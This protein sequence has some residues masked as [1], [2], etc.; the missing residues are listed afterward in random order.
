MEHSS[1]ADSLLSP[2]QQF[3]V[4]Y[5][6]EHAITMKVLRAYPPGKADLRPHPKCRTAKELA[7]VFVLE[8][9]LGTMVM[10]DY[11][12]SNPPGGEMP[13]VPDT[14]P[15]VI[16]ALERAHADHAEVIESLSDEEIEAPVTFFVGPGK[17]GDWSRREFLWFLLHDQ[18]HHRGQLSIYLRMADGQVPSIYGPSADEAWF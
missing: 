17:L 13:P 4:A 2:K 12:A 3:L 10:R 14:W 1:A 6:R 7:F 8:R 16:A 9:G 15:E 11:F 5:E 18:I